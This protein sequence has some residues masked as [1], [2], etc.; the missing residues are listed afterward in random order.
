MEQGSHFGVQSFAFV[1]FAHLKNF[2][3]SAFSCNYVHS[4]A[5]SVVFILG[6]QNF[7]SLFP[8]VIQGALKK[9]QSRDQAKALMRILSLMKGA[10][11]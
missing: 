4:C 11:E 6:V 5:F 3:A 9:N 1:P 2:H 8:P 7:S 10:I